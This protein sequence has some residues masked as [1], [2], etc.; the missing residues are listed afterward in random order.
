[1]PFEPPISKHEMAQRQAK[2]SLWQGSSPLRDGDPVARY[3]AARHIVV[4]PPVLR[5]HPMARYD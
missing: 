1:M 5:Y 4:R 2:N 3:L